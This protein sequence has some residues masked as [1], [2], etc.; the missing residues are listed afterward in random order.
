M[1]RFQGL[2]RH[3]PCGALPAGG[4]STSF[5]PPFV[6]MTPL[7]TDG[8]GSG[9]GAGFGRD[10]AEKWR[11]RGVSH[12][13]LM[14]TKTT[15]AAGL[16]PTST[17][18][19]APSPHQIPSGTSP[20]SSA[21]TAHPALPYGTHTRQRQ[22]VPLGSIIAR[23]GRNLI[24]DRFVWSGLCGRG[25]L[26][27]SAVCVRALGRSALWAWAL[28]AVRHLHMDAGWDTNWSP[29]LG[30]GGPARLTPVP[31]AG[32]DGSLSGGRRTTADG[33]R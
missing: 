24:V 28:W 22:T 33:R 26:S 6:G 10:H 32:D 4:W 8:P 31:G 5:L 21:N 17:R 7:A 15:S 27:S 3:R 1:Q 2:D 25:G 23:T 29:G 16:N 18:T 11:S 20:S 19:C 12:T 14:V 30:R 9:S 13:T